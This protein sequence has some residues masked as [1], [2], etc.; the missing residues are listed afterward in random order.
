MNDNNDKPSYKNYSHYIQEGWSNEPKESFKELA[1]H[2]V[3]VGGKPTGRL[4]DI[5][6]A[7][8]ELLGYL[9]T[10]FNDLSYTGMDVFDDLLEK[11]CSFLP[12]ADFVN[13]SV[14]NVPDEMIST[15]DFVIAIGV[16]SVFDETE[17]EDFWHNLLKVSKPGGTVIVLSPLNEYG[18]DTMIRHRKRVG[19]ECKEW[20][21]GWNIFSTDT[22]REIIKRKGYE[23]EITPFRPDLLLSQASDPVRTWTLATESNPRQLT[24]GMKLLIDHYFMIVRT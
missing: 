11:A 21:T 18:V 6:C 1:R 20:E 23:L 10:Q 4:L 2:I 22:I 12:E 17:I 14:L 3:S 8:G 13:A 7:T 19:N 9:I 24:N 15:Y 5:G 16:M